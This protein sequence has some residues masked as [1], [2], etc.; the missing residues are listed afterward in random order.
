M[1]HR[2][3]NLSVRTDKSNFPYVGRIQP[4]RLSIVSTNLQRLSDMDP[5]REFEICSWANLLPV[6]TAQAATISAA[7]LAV[8]IENRVQF[9]VRIVQ[10]L[11][12]LTAV[13]D[14]Q[15]AAGA[16]EKARRSGGPSSRNIGEG[17]LCRLGVAVALHGDQIA[18]DVCGSS[19]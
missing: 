1:A 4:G 2:S 11:A 3:D 12:G 14:D 19:R 15:V 6:S 7:S 18:D 10:A 5:V 17:S 16:K 8:P 13:I 9:F